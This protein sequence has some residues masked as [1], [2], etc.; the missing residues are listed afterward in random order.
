[1]IEVAVVLIGVAGVGLAFLSPAAGIVAL[2]YGLAGRHFLARQRARATETRRRGEA[3]D[4]LSTTAAD[5]RAG[6]SP[7]VF[8]LPDP[9]LDRFSRAAQRLSRRTGAPLADL[10]ERLEAHQRD[11]ARVEKAA[12]AQAAGTRLTALLLAALPI[13]ALGL[14]HLIGADALGALFGTTLGMACA[15]AAI[16]LQL[17]GLLWAERLARPRSDQLHAEVAVA[18]DLLA[19]ALRTGVPVSAAVLSVGEA[20]EGP[21]SGRLMQIG[22][23]LR[24]GVSPRQAWQRLADLAAAQGFI[25]SAQR[26]AES[27]AALSRALARSADDLRAD[28]AHERQAQAQRAA[29]LLVLPLGLCFLPAFVIG[30]LVPVVVAVLGDVL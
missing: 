2:C 25:T 30:G 18:A 23:E 7:A 22:R 1:M 8:T 21:L 17:S 24:E 10:I 29:V 27:G 13:A 3:L 9:Q 6:A 11:L 19:A 15:A 12:A 26:S 20:L 16:V 14:G 5:L 4:L 28:A